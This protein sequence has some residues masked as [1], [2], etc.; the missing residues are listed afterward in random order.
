[1]VGTLYVLLISILI[2]FIIHLLKVVS[3]FRFVLLTCLAIGS[4]Y[5]VGF[6]SCEVF[7]SMCNSDPLVG[8]GYIIFT[9]LVLA[10]SFVLEVAR[11]NFL[12]YL[13]NK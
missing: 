9:L 6:L 8:L 7:D 10:V 13:K 1:M 11:T 5:L 4:T 2:V 12:L 3:L